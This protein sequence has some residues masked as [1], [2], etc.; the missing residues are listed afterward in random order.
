MGS[1]VG[2]RIVLVIPGVA[3]VGLIIIVAEMGRRMAVRA[4]VALLEMMI[5]VGG[6]TVMVTNPVLAGRPRLGGW[7]ACR[8]L[9]LAV[10]TGALVINGSPPKVLLTRIV[11]T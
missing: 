7:V 5:R 10:C 3:V 11:L 1:K 9:I 2:V 8:E 6:V 4:S